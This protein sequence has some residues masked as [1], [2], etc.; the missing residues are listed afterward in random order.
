MLFQKGG[1]TAGTEKVVAKRDIA[2]VEK[3]KGKKD[4]K[5][6]SGDI[7]ETPSAKRQKTGNTTQPRISKGSTGIAAS[8]GSGSGSNFGSGSALTAFTTTPSKKGKE[9]AGRFFQ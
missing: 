4:K 5:R 3:Y 7:L 6:N 2:E 1:N 8:A 9:P